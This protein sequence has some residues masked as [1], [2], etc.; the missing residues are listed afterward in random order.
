MRQTL[1]FHR[2][3][4]SLGWEVLYNILMESG[5]PMKL[6]SL[7]K[8]CLNDVYSKVHIGKHLPNVFCNQNCL[9]QGDDLPMP[10]NFALVYVIRKIQETS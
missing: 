7:N 6:D 3:Q 4:D 8:M 5:L 2:L 1:M 9:K 10:F